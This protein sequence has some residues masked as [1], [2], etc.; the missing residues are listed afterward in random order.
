MRLLLYS[1][2]AGQGFKYE[3]CEKE[4]R[5][6]KKSSHVLHRLNRYYH[7]SSPRVQTLLRGLSPAYLRLGGNAADYTVY[8]N[9]PGLLNHVLNCKLVSVFFPILPKSYEFIVAR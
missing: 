3:T 8:S 2:D 1:C 4:K 5:S 9:K 7:F 6:L